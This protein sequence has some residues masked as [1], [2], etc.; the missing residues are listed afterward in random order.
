[1]FLF[2]FRHVLVFFWMVRGM[3]YGII[4]VIFIFILFLLP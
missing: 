1:M 2:F 4:G 3:T